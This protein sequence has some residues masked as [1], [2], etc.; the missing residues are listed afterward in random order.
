MASDGP[1]AVEA[2]S[3][4]FVDSL[5]A[6]GVAHVCITPGSRSTPLTIAFAMQPAIRPW[7]HLDER[8]SAFFALGLAK[9]TGRPVALVC[10]SGTAAANYYPAVT[11]AHLSGVPLIVCTTD[12]PPR[13]RDVGAEQTMPQAGM[14]GT[15]TRF[16]QDLPTPHGAAFEPGFFATVALRA[17]RESLGPYPGPVHLNFPFEEPLIGPGA[18]QQRPA[19]VTRTVDSGTPAP[20]AADIQAAVGV[21]KGARRPLIVAGPEVSAAAVAPIAALA[22]ALGAPLLADPLSGLRVGSHDRSHVMASYDAVLRDRRAA[23]D[24]EPDVVVRF[25]GRPTSKALNGLLDDARAVHILCEPWGSW[26]VG[27]VAMDQV[28]PGDPA[29]SAAALASALPDRPGADAGWLDAWK[30][31][32]AAAQAAMRHSALQPG[33]LFEGRVFIELQEALP[34]GATVVAGNSMPVRDLD[35]FTVS[36]AKPL[37][38]ISNRGANGIDGVNSTAL[39]VAAAGGGPTVLVIGDLSF[40]HDLTGLWAAKRHQLDLTVILIN[41]NGGGIF[42]YL[43]QAAHEDIFETWFGTPGDI[44][45]EHAVRLFGGEYERIDSWDALQAA[46]ARNAKG[47]RVLELR[48]DRVANTA[49]HRAAWQRAASAAWDEAG[50][51]HATV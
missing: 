40:Y 23:G 25:G 28:L 3:A 47:L 16:A 18:S 20:L 12:R 6:H 13:L 15:T 27:S 14:F 9:A 46:L 26:R 21:L 29:V 7:L 34:A 1:L 48:T 32:D 33:P 2:A 11:E 17:V 50:V 45:F 10:T 37:R 42:H 41:N 22:A 5:V 36:D 49:W 35:S 38:F 43:P 39:G 44:E 8:A 4:A 24:C 19:P 31:R 30:A 51:A